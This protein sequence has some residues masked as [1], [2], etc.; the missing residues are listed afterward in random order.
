MKW[1][2]KQIGVVLNANIETICVESQNQY[3]LWFSDNYLK[4]YLHIQ[5][6]SETVMLAADPI[7]PMGMPLLEYSFN[8]NIIKINYTHLHVLIFMKEKSRI[9][10]PLQLVVFLTGNNIKSWA[11]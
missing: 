8:C 9:T 3:M 7:N 4:F 2:L 11:I 6:E 10:N 1:D 5:P